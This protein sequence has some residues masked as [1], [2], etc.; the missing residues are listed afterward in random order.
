[1]ATNRNDDMDR[2]KTEQP[3]RRARRIAIPA[4]VA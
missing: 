3:T 4:R 1:M 2:N